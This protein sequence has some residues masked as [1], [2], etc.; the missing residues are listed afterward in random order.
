MREAVGAVVT[1]GHLVTTPHQEVAEGGQDSQG[2]VPPPRSATARVRFTRLGA[3][4]QGAR[5]SFERQL[6]CDHT[7]IEVLTVVNQ[8]MCRIDP[9]NDGKGWGR[10]GYGMKCIER[11]CM[12]EGDN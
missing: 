10:V 12:C 1:I 7:R 11:C 8:G 9:G 6:L 2:M 4:H 5:L 3:P